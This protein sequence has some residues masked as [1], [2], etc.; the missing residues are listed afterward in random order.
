MWLT[1]AL[2]SDSRDFA[3]PTGYALDECHVDKSGRWLMLLETRPGGLRRNR[4]VDL[5]RN[6]ITTIDDVN[7]A[8]GHLDMG[9]GYAVASDM[10]NPLP[11]STIF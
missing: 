2:P 3:P 4:V 9:F 5:R 10:F 11:N 7:G 1:R 6:R 8:L